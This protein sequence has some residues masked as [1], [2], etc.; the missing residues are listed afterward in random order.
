MRGGAALTSPAV[1]TSTRTMPTTSATTVRPSAT[2]GRRRSPSRFDRLGVACRLAQQP[3]TD[4]GDGDDGCQQRQLDD[5]PRAVVAVGQRIPRADLPPRVEHSCRRQHDDRAQRDRR[6][7]ARQ[8]EHI[9]IGVPPRSAPPARRTTP[10]SPRG[11]AR[12]PTKPSATCRPVM[13]WPPAATTA[14]RADAQHGEA[15]RPPSLRTNPTCAAAPATVAISMPARRTNHHRPALERATS[16]H[17]H[18]SFT[19]DRRLRGDHHD[20]ADRAD[21]QRRQ[22]HA[23]ASGAAPPATGPAATGSP[24]RR[25]TR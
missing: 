17:A 15:R 24:P 10:T 2:F 8:R 11:A 22:Q 6:E 16:P 7:A 19:R 13:P 14:S 18:T 12:W 23:F 5:Q 21:R 1:A 20:G 4:H 3:P 9:A 25:P